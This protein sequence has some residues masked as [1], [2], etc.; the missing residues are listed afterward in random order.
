MDKMK[1]MDDGR[2]ALALA[3]DNGHRHVTRY[4]KSVGVREA[5]LEVN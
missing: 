3:S 2:T 4:L 5:K 1:C